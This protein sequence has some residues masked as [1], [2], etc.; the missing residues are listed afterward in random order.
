MLQERGLSCNMTLIIYQQE[1]KV[2]SCLQRMPF[3]KSLH[4]IQEILLGFSSVYTKRFLDIWGCTKHV[5]FT[6]LAKSIQEHINLFLQCHVILL[7]E[8]RRSPCCVLVVNL[9]DQSL[10]DTINNLLLSQSLTLMLYH[11]HGSQQH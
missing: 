1:P 9:S 3:V 11:I 6:R 4:P 5:S 8:L 2:N 10:G 7:L